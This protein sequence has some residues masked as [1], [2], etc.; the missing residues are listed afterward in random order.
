MED[1][2]GPFDVDMFASEWTCLVDKFYSKFLCPGTSGVDAFAQDWSQGNLYCHPPIGDVFRVLRLA[3]TQKARGV[4]L[5]PDWSASINLVGVKQ[6]G[7]KVRLADSFYP[8]FEAPDWW[9]NKVFSGRYG[10][11]M[12]VF[13]FDFR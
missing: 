3:E 13:Q 9:S 12:L 6:Y 7:N 1:K 8:E 2:F 4:L 10:F 5:I 11:K